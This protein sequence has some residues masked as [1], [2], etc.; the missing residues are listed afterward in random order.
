MRRASRRRACAARRSCRST[1][2]RHGLGHRPRQHAAGAPAVASSR[3]PC[4]RSRPRAA[5]RLGDPLSRSAAFERCGETRPNQPISATPRLRPPPAQR[6]P[7]ESTCPSSAVPSRC[8]HVAATV[9]VPSCRRRPPA[10]S[11]GASRRRDTASAPAGRGRARPV[12]C[13][14]ALP[15]AEKPV[16]AGAAVAP[17][18]LSPS[19]SRWAGRDPGR[20]GG[21]SHPRQLQVS[22]DPCGSTRESWSSRPSQL[23]TARTTRPATRR[24]ACACAA[25]AAERRRRPASARPASGGRRASLPVVH[26]GAL[27]DVPDA[28][29][30]GDQDEDSACGGR[31]RV[32]DQTSLAR[33]PPLP[34][35]RSGRRLT[36]ASSPPPPVRSR[37]PA[38][39]RSSRVPTPSASVD[40]GERVCDPDP[41][42]RLP[43][44]LLGQARS[45]SSHR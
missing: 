20:G 3:E 8:A 2:H 33:G 23:A 12:T 35:A 18:G 13:E 28:E 31:G 41:N 14:S 30:D 26:V 7:S 10:A 45:R 19:S 17:D 37:R 24:V 25:T 27:L 1:R 21:D 22:A 16:R 29:E 5:S 44:E 34:G 40:A 15:V 39:R 42:P 4:V 11:T 6:R 38:K 9:N 36:P 32:L 43:L